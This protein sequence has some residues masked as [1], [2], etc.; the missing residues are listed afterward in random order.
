MNNENKDI[1]PTISQLKSPDNVNPAIQDVENK[2]ERDDDDEEN[3]KKEKVL[4]I[5]TSSIYETGRV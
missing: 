5:R 1:S 2:D 4:A 3:N